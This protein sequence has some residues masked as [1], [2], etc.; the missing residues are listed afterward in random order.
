MT[1]PDQ[2]IAAARVPGRLKAG[3]HGSWTIHRVYIPEDSP[4]RE[5]V[6]H[7]ILTSLHRMTCASPHTEY[8][9][10]VMED[11][12]EELRKHLPIW[13]S[14][15]GRILVSGLGLGCVVRGLLA[16]PE[17]QHVDVVEIDRTILRVVG[18]EFADNP[19]VSLHL[20]D[21]LKKRWPSGTRFDWAWHD[22]WTEDG[23]GLPL[24]KLH[25]ELIARYQKLVRNKQGAWAL[26]RVVKHLWPG[27]IG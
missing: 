17:V 24:H 12:A 14:G 1:R 22:I 9:D 21:A 5:R 16:K 2:F 27:L 7:P 13:V 23:N 26:P 6:G 20:G 8:G 11:S 18:A 3:I 15:R 25:L 10:V 19:R 4:H